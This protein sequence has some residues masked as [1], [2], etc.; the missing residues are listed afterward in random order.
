M[1]GNNAIAAVRSGGC[2]G[3]CACSRIGLTIPSVTIAGCD[4][5]LC[6]N[7]WINREVENMLD[8]INVGAYILLSESVFACRGV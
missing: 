8:A 1:E 3:I 7:S 6:I 2:V 5:F 4:V